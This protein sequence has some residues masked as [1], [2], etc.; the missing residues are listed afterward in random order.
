MAGTVV[1]QV[2][3]VVQELRRDSCRCGWY[4]AVGRGPDKGWLGCARRVDRLRRFLSSDYCG[5]SDVPSQ[6]SSASLSTDRLSS[7]SITD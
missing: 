5:S 1:V 4:S 3:Q 6:V 2:V 7:D